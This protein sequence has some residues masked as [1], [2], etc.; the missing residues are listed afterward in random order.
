MTYSLKQWYW[1]ILVFGNKLNAK[2]AF[3][4]MT[5][6]SG[7]WKL[8][9]TW[10]LPRMKNPQGWIS[11][12]DPG[13]LKWLEEAG[14]TD[15]GVPPRNPRDRYHKQGMHDLTLK[16]LRS[17]FCPAS[18]AMPKWG[19][20]R[21]GNILAIGTS[22][23]RVLYWCQSLLIPAVI[24]KGWNRLKSSVGISWQS[25][26]LLNIFNKAIFLRHGNSTVS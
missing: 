3:Q 26:T 7:F 23:L 16:T 13:N 18:A 22:R 4:N 2:E 14:N 21:K 6:D 11:T 12:S 15:S 8:C 19:T 24:N 9:K 17:H 5:T 20:C 10:A 1:I 25:C